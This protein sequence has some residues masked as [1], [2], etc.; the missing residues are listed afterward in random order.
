MEVG[1]WLG[2]I[3]ILVVAAG[4][5]LLLVSPWFPPAR[6][7][8]LWIKVLVWAVLAA[9]VAAWGFF[10]FLGRLYTAERRRPGSR[11]CLAWLTC[12]L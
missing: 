10:V 8:K 3:L 7:W 11:R 6:Q 9:G 5:K 1:R 2:F 4:A 12:R